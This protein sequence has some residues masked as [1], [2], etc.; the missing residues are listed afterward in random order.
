V[1]LTSIRLSVSVGR[2]NNRLDFVGSLDNGLDT[3]VPGYP[4][5][6]KGFF[7]YYGD[8]YRQL[9]IRHKNPRWMF[10]LS[11]CFLVFHVFFSLK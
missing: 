1:F 9:R 5:T 11:E 2:R 6:F 10:E 3:R 8:S 4:E 7:I